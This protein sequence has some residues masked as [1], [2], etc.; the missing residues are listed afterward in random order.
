MFAKAFL[1]AVA[2]QGIVI[3][4]GK[5]RLIEQPRAP[6]ETAGPRWAAQCNGSADFNKP[7]PPVRIHGN[8]YLVGTC[9]ISSIFI[10]KL[11]FLLRALAPHLPKNWRCLSRRQS[12]PSFLA[13]PS[14]FRRTLGTPPAPPCRFG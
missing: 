6:I 13:A 3:P 2:A 14:R 8:T 5:P 1:L 10:A 12:S 11:G 4:F 7:S 9:G